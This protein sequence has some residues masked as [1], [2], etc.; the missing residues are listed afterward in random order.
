LGRNMRVRSIRLMILITDFAS[1]PQVPMA[2]ERVAIACLSYNPK[3]CA[4]S[5]NRREALCLLLAMTIIPC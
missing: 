5:E 3:G 2:Q 4:K 1:L